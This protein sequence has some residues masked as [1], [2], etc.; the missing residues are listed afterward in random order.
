[1]NINT[2]IKS[3]YTTKEL[4]D[5]LR[6]KHT[7]IN[8]YLGYKTHIDNCA[9]CWNKW[10]KIRWDAAYQ[11]QGLVELREF[12]GNSF[13]NYYDSSWALANEWVKI[14]PKTEDE[15]ADFYKNTRNYLFNLTIWYESGDRK[16]LKKDLVT[17]INKFEIKSIIDFGCGVG[18]DS[19]FLLENN[20]KVFMI[21]YDCPST[22]FLNWR[23]KR[24][25][26]QNGIFIDSESLKILPEADMFWAID[27]LEHLPNPLSVVEMLTE[28]TKVFV[29]HSEFNEFAGGRHPCH[30]SFEEIKLINKL[31]EKGFYNVPWNNLSVWI[32]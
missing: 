14:N 26:I 27:V 24:R 9:S 16:D 20:I 28:K 23:I 19:L 11:N 17:L 10:N 12:M 22:R 29:H 18:N 25:N 30:I 21:D 7:D 4:E 5:Y 6:N 1:M 13:E 15:I 8:P 32:R 31:R 2:P 3:H